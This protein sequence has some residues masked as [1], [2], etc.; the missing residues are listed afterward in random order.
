MSVLYFLEGMRTPVLDGIVSFLTLFGDEVIFMAI[1]MIV[2]WCIDKHQ[3]YYLLCVGFLG[4]VINQFLKM[5]FRVPRPWIKDPDFTIV[6]SA[7]EGASGYSFPSGHTQT[8]I[9]LFGGLARWNKNA[10]IR[11]IGIAMCVLVPFSRLYL[12]VHT[13]T[14]VAVSVALGLV[15]VFAGYPVFKKAKD[16]PALMYIVLG[17]LTA[18]MIG[19]I[20]FLYLYPF[21][22]EA[23][24][25]ENIE[26]L[27]SAKKN[28]F[29][30]LGCNLGMLVVYAVDSMYTRFETKAVWWAQLIKAGGGLMVVLL[31]KEGLKA[32]LDALFG[33]ALAARSLRYFLMVMAAGV[34]WPMTFGWFSRLG[35]KE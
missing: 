28:A 23:Y 12:G 1:S 9:G 5:F 31:V 26:N 16:K 18:V 32:P 7:R 13:P 30:L 11:I 27:L 10:V 17:V 33:G 35:D 22:E 6:E 24:N 29:T 4:T 14:D 8:S 20:C 25:A 21:P 15:L 34:L 3:G 2:F 19:F